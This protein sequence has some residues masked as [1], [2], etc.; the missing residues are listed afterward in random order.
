MM[1]G[2]AAGVCWVW[3]AFPNTVTRNA[4]TSTAFADIVMKCA[5]RHSGSK[6]SDAKCADR[7]S[8]S[9]HCDAKCADRHS[10]SK[11]NDEFS[12]DGGETTGTTVQKFF[13]VVTSFVMTVL[14][15]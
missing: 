1:R 10:V 11:L 13:Q 8:V 9:K 15:S 7:H 5:D 12:S 3:A 14:S 6:H 4:L 2:E